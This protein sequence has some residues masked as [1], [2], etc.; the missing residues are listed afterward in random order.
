MTQNSNHYGSSVASSVLTDSSGEEENGNGYFVRYPPLR[1]IVLPHKPTPRYSAVGDGT[2]PM[3]NPIA[4]IW[5]VVDQNAF[6][7]AVRMSVLLGTSALFALIPFREERDGNR[8][9]YY[10]EGMWIFVSV[11]FV[12]WFPSLDA[13]SVME[14]IAQRLIGTFIGAILGLSCGFAAIW[15]FKFDWVGQATFLAISQYV[16]LFGIIWIAGQAKVGRK[17]V[18][19]SYAYAT[20][21]C[22]LTFSICSVPFGL[23]EN[24]KNVPKWHMGIWRIFNVVVGCLLGAVGSIVIYSKS[25]MDVLHEKTARQVT[26]AGEASKAV[27]HLAADCLSGN[28]QVHRLADE[29]LNSPLQTT[30]RWKL[31]PT[32][33]TSEQKAND[34]DVALQKY[35]DAIADW[36]A[37]KALFP[38]APYDPFR[39]GGNAQSTRELQA[40]IA[41]TLA[42]SLRI[43]STIVVLDGMLRSETDFE[44]KTHDY[45]IFLETGTLIADM[46][47]SPILQ[48]SNDIAAI[49]LFDRLM[50]IR[51]R[52]A[53]LS[54]IFGRR[55]ASVE[56]LE[57]WELGQF[58]STLLVSTSASAAASQ[59]PNRPH[60]D[61]DLGRGIP[62]LPTLRV[63]NSLFFLQLV[64]HLIL[65]SLRLFQAW[66][67]VEILPGIIDASHRDDDLESVQSLIIG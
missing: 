51:R 61:D 32:N 36:N 22:V 29:L 27:L 56:A 21:L 34:A 62:K 40:E 66:K 53:E 6:Q 45:V 46:L 42:R 55:P 14:K 59:S 47:K 54:S 64:E 2:L 43:Q 33:A 9:R 25:T 7:F 12:C 67:Q 23:A 30:Q 15:I 5:D 65:R 20:I 3:K 31:D 18:I 19:R 10:P 58:K 60:D 41:K 49:Q 57:E 52:M 44:F 8:L 35:E 48:S 13:A 50:E 1:N 39:F 16:F 11:L 4:R 63:S 38:L 17:K 37:S 24:T 26:L 28:V